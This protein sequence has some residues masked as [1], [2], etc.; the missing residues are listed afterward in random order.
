[1]DI[2]LIIYY[3]CILLGAVLSAFIGFIIGRKKALP[4]KTLIIFIS[5]ALITGIIGAVLM[6]QLQNF[7]MSLTGLPYSMSR[8]RIFG[9][10]LFTPVFIYFPVKY[11]GG[12]YKN[13]TDI[14]T[15]GLYALLGCSKIGCAVYGCCYGIECAV[16]VT[17][18]FEDHTVFPVQLLES[19]LCFILCIAAYFVLMNKKHRKGT[20]YPLFIILYGIMRFLVEFLRCY[21]LEERT[22]FFGMNFWQ[23]FSIIS[24]VVG[25]V[26]L[27]L[28]KKKQKTPPR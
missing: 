24:I 9:G 28:L 15:P 7:I 27:I 4:K 2:K 18:Q 26:W 1:M 13:I 21:P 10:L 6:A 11:L 25:I 23:L 22:Y 20:L 5:F 16:G 12:D 14:F 17:T 3:L 19:I 8:L